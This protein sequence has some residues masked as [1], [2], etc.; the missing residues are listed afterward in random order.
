MDA[1][2]DV[3]DELKAMRLKMADIED[4]A[5]RNNI[6][7]RGVPESIKPAELTAYL[8]KLM[9]TALPDV[10]IDRAH[11][12]PKLSFL[13]D[14]IP[15]DVIARIHFYHVKDQLMRYAKKH[16]ALPD[17]FAAIALYADL[18][19]ATLMARHNLVPITKILHNHK[20]LYKWGLP[21]KLLLEMHN[22]LHAITSL[23]KGMELLRKCLLIFVQAYV[24]A[25]KSSVVRAKPRTSFP[26][27]SFTGWIPVTRFMQ[28][29]LL[30]CS[31]L[32]NNPVWFILLV[33]FL[34]YDCK[35]NLISGYTHIQQQI[36]NMLPTKFYH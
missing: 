27:S 15:R 31:Q 5:C 10:I 26:P 1:H 20:I 24:S 19:Q 14:K 16:P 34:F 12:L 23:E 8:Q 25:Q 21:A 2:F 32:L 9:T 13:S 3:E 29:N 4:R 11:S 30:D 18:S 28:Q 7:F 6:K 35:I 17:P 36:D 33:F 22:K